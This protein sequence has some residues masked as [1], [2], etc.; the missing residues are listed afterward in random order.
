MEFTGFRFL[1]QGRGNV[2]KMNLIGLTSSC[3]QSR[4]NAYTARILLFDGNV[5]SSCVRSRNRTRIVVYTYKRTYVN[6]CYVI[7]GKVY[8]I[9]FGQR[10][11]FAF[12]CC[13][14]SALVSSGALFNVVVRACSSFCRSLMSA[15]VGVK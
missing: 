10:S 1:F 2:H 8:G 14:R 5:F 11:R 12:V 7:R 3:R 4:T 13:S 15:S 6:M 9:T